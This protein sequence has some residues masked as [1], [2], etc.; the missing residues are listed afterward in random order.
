MPS[1]R[2]VLRSLWRPALLLWALLTFNLCACPL[3][4][5]SLLV[6]HSQHDPAVAG[7]SSCCGW[8]TGSRPWATCLCGAQRRSGG[9]G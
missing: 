8:S 1:H 3:G 2:P 4:S 9:R 6:A 5:L 7:R